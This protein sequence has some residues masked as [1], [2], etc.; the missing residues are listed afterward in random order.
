MESVVYRTAL[1]HNVPMIFWGDSQQEQTTPME[2]LARKNLK[3]GRGTI[4]KHFNPDYYRY[5]A[6]CLK[7]RREFKVPGNNWLVRHPRLKN[8]NIEEVLEHHRKIIENGPE[9]FETRQKT[10]VSFHAPL[11]FFP[12]ASFLR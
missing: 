11:I 10:K 8:K 3:L 12:F 7:Q 4:R 2:K 9:Q 1:E 5:E 6:A